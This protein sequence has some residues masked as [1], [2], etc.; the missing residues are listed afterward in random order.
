MPTYEYQCE[1]C[2]HR[3]DLRQGYDAET[4]ADCPVC[5][6]QARRRI[7]LVPVIFKGS[8]WYVTDY[9]RSNSTLK[10]SGSGDHSGEAAKSGQDSST[11]T[12][13][14]KSESKKE[15]QAE[16]VGQAF[17]KSSAQEAKTGS[18]ASET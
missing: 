2:R 4:V 10:E 6:A 11:R 3:F 13:T 12:T 5:G 9:N 8:G 15:A 16:G 7:S 14:T 17:E 1:V 18:G